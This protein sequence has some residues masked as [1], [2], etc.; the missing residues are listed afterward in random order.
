MQSVNRI[1]E[2]GAVVGIWTDFS[3]VCYGNG[4]AYEDMI[5][6]IIVLDAGGERKS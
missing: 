1:V 4:S 2:V 6:I 3:V 5:I